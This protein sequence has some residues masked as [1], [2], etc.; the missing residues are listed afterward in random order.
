MNEVVEYG[1]MVL[2]G[3]VLG[4]RASERSLKDWV[5]KEWGGFLGYNHVSLIIPRG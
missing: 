2:V 3:Q 5:D 1:E 4:F